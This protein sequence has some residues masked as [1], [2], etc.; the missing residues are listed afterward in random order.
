[1]MR[2]KRPAARPRLRLT[3]GRETG[4]ATHRLPLLRLSLYADDLTLAASGDEDDVLDT[5]SR[6]TDLFVARLEV[7]FGLEVS[8]IKS[9]A[10]SSP[11]SL[12]SRLVRSPRRRAVGARRDTKMLGAPF[13]GGRA[14]STKVLKARLKRFRECVAQK[15]GMTGH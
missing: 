11:P 7:I 5:V 1:M 12:A 8:V 10:V 3:Q 6:S 13:A 14:R 4:N 2:Q 9:F 15:G